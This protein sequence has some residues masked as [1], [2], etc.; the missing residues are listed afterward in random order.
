MDEF[1]DKY[2]KFNKGE[3]ISILII[4]ALIV[5]MVVLCL[6]PPFR[7]TVSDVGFHPLDSLN[8]AHKR[9]FQE[10]KQKE[11]AEQSRTDYQEPHL[12]PFPFNPNGMSEE[13]WQRLGLTDRQIRNIKN[14]EAKGGRFL[15][16]NDLKKLYT[17]SDEDFAALEP[18]IVI[19]QRTPNVA[20]RSSEWKK[21]EQTDSKSEKKEAL[22]IPMV[23]IN[24]VDSATLVALPKVSPYLA[25]RVL[26]YRERLG[27]YVQLEQLLEVKGL[28]SIKF[29]AMSPYLQLERM[30]PVKVDVNRDDFKDLLRH[31]YLGY[32]QVKTI[33]RYRESRGM[34]KDWPQLQKV[35]GEKEPL[36]PLLEFYIDY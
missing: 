17:I 11:H 32:E 35:V 34:I 21:D 10:Q 7:N 25:S 24:T 5:A 3:R 27:G 15:S 20:N 12:T 8:R 31:P 4:A 29:E 16:K 14:Y 18:Y 13:E 36:N 28:D 19:P 1:G 30:E 26:G 23:E 9:A 22:P 2:L 33:V 6:M